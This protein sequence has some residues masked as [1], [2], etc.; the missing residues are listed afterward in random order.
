LKKTYSNKI[1]FYSLLFVFIFSNV[2]CYGALTKGRIESEEKGYFIYIIWDA[3]RYDYYEWANSGQYQ[4]HQHLT[5][6]SRMVFY[7][8]TQVLVYLQ[9]LIQCKLY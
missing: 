5:N 4:E 2:I 3:F 8:Q 9:L 1:L 7:L 6:L